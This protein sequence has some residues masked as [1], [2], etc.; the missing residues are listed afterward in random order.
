MITRLLFIISGLFILSSCA[1]NQATRN[2]SARRLQKGR[3]TEDS[4][5]VYDLPYKAGT[6]KLLVQGYYSR[7]SHKYRIALDFKMKKGTAVCAARS[8]VVIGLKEDSDQGGLDSKYYRFANIVRIRHADGTVA[9]Y[10]HLQHNGVLVN[11][12]DTVQRGQVIALSGSTG[13]SA[14][15]HLHF[16][17][18]ATDENG[19][20]VGL[21]T[22]FR[23]GNKSRYLRPMHW[24]RNRKNKRADNE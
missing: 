15:P 1:L 12:G 3:Q 22:R 20:R 7:F 8:G 9:I 11:L 19:K 2:S 14:F 13:Y 4:S 21:P 24:Y 17:V 16:A 6:K 10:G 23:I 5:F 18:S